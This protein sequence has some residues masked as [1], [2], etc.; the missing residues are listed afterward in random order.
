MT[1]DTLAL[2]RQAISA[3]LT[4]ALPEHREIDWSQSLTSE[5]GLDSV[6]IMNLVM[7]IEDELDLSVPVDVL[8]EVNTLNDLAVR[9]S[10]LT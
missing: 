5:A 9:L 3:A 6:Q 10:K 2:A 8:A 1:T 4:R 7:E